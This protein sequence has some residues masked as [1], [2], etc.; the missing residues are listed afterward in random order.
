VAGKL[1]K[2]LDVAQAS[3]SLPF[4]HL[5]VCDNGK[6]P[7][8]IGAVAVGGLPFA[9]VLLLA[10]KLG[11]LA[12]HQHVAVGQTYEIVGGVV[13]LPFVPVFDA[14]RLGFDVEDFGGEVRQIE[15]V[16]FYG[17]LVGHH[18]PGLDEVEVAGNVAAPVAYGS[19]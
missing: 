5:T 14:D 13:S 12:L 11:W 4:P 19:H 8:E 7:V 18:L 16:S 10:Y 2:H 15:E 1:G 9:P 6:V 17:G 3:A